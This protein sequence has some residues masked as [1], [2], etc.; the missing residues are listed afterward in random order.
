[1]DAQRDSASGKVVLSF[2]VD[3]DGTV[4]DVKVERG[5]YPSLDQEAV[6]VVQASRGWIPGKQR[7]VPVRVKYNIPISFNL[8]R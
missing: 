3:A 7:G 6:R 8:H 5:V 2:F 4:D 1:M